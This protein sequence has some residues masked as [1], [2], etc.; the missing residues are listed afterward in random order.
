[1]ASRAQVRNWQIIETGS[2][3]ASL[4]NRI[5]LGLTTVRALASCAPISD[6]RTEVRIAR[7]F[8]EVGGREVPIGGKR[9]DVG[10][11]EWLYVDDRIR[12][13]LGSKGSLFVHVREEADGS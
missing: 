9:D 10:F 5:D 6:V 2:P 1:M 4:E 12:V 13:T 11:V 7:V 3:E 8:T